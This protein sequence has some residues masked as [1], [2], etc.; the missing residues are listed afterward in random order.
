[1]KATIENG[2][3]N[4][5]AKTRFLQLFNLTYKDTKKMYTFGGIFYQGDTDS[6]LR[7]EVSNLSYISH[8]DRFVEIN[9]PFLTPKEKLYLDSCVKAESIC[10][11]SEGITGLKKEDVD[12]YGKFYKY[13]PQFFESIY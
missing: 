12:S 10:I 7:S 3:N 2:L 13:Y 5:T 11:D 1:M 6:R 4:Q 8:D 9:C